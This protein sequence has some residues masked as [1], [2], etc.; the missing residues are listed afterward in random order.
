MR[1]KKIVSREC[2]SS[3]NRGIP[4]YRSQHC[5]NVLKSISQ[6]CRSEFLSESARFLVRDQT[7]TR[8]IRLSIMRNSNRTFASDCADALVSL[9]KQQ[10]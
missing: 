1:K 9:V 10:D 6:F 3:G 7:L 8:T 5:R 2:I 4:I